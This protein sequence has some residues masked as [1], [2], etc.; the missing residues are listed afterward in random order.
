MPQL[1]GDHP[2]GEVGCREAVRL[3]WGVFLAAADGDP[4]RL[5]PMVELSRA[6]QAH[7]IW[8]LGELVV[9]AYALACWPGLPYEDRR[10]AARDHIAALAL[11]LAADADL[12]W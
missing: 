8:H 2:A 1:P 6:D 3:A 5:A 11:R 4:E 12:D 10:C 7:V 9:A